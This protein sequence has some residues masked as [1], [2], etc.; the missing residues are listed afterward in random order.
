MFAF[1]Q[2]CQLYGDLAVDYVS[3]LG[4]R[5]DEQRRITKIE[6]RIDEAQENQGKSLFATTV[7]FV[8]F[9]HIIV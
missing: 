8:C 1:V 6:N 5:S 4:I 2:S 7:L 3:I 9:Y